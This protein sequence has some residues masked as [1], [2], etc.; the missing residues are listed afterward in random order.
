[1]GQKERLEGSKNEVRHV[2]LKVKDVKDVWTAGSVCPSLSQLC[3]FPIIPYC[4]FPKLT[5][6]F[7]DIPIFRVLTVRGSHP[8]Q[9]RAGQSLP[10]LSALFTSSF[11][12]GAA[13]CMFTTVPWAFSAFCLGSIENLQRICSIIIFQHQLRLFGIP[14]INNDLYDLC[15]FFWSCY[16]TPIHLPTWR[17]SCLESTSP[18]WSMPTSW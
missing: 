2:L 15:V 16:I 4:C 18:S 17:R 14:W 13:G 1:M 8:N 3:L 11:S 12:K 5:N 9:G 7:I 6:V 10:A